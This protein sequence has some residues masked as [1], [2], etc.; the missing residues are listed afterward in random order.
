MSSRTAR[1][2]QRNPVSKKPKKE[3]ENGSQEHRGSWS[4]IV[5]NPLIPALQKQKLVNLSV[6]PAWSTE[7]VPGQ[8]G[9]HRETI[10]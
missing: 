9:L 5:L 4:Y 10:S 2:T 7:Q 6:R 1:T 8:L 3:K